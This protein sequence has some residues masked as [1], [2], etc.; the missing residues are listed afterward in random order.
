MVQGH[1]SI[2]LRCDHSVI[3]KVYYVFDTLFMAKGI[4]VVYRESPPEDGP[5]LLYSA[6]KPEDRQAVRCFFI[7]HHPLVW[8]YFDAEWDAVSVERVCGLHTVFS[9]LI[10]GVDSSNDIPFDIV[11]NAFFF[12]SSWS[13]RVGSRSSSQR[14]LF[15]NSIYSRLSVPQDIVDRYLAHIYV[16]LE[17]LYSRAGMCEMKPLEWPNRASYVVILSHDVDF[18][19]S[20]RADILF[21]G[22]KTLARHL[23]R[24]SD[25]V[26]AFKAGRALIWSLVSG[27]DPY[28]CVPDILSKERSLGVRSS[29]QVAVGHRH[30]N[31]VNYYLENEMICNYLRA[32]CDAEFDLCLHGS[33]LSTSNSNWYAEEVELLSQRLGRPLGSRQHFLSFDYDTLFSI[34]ER[35]GIKYDMSMGFPDEIGPRAGFSFPYF[36]YCIKEDRPYKVLQLNLFLMD[37]TLRSYLGLKGLIAWGSIQNVVDDLRRKGGCTSVVWH[38]IVFG[39]ARD[40]GY[41]ELFWKLVDYVQSTGGLATDGRSICNFWF[42]RARNYTSFSGVIMD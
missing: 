12:L 10:D 29:F 17:T 27:K 34:Q 42:D 28:G 38:P 41:G 25:P 6:D 40:P 39:G 11:A 3:N 36:P 16:R 7:A 8:D 5:W 20:G 31:D 24:Q 26:D 2:V 37:V 15:S 33:Y 32:I 4:S 1:L 9:D 35:V 14:A 21:Q 13:E 19:P 23:V 18:I 22:L 30:P